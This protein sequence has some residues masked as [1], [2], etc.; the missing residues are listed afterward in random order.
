MKL[1]KIFKVC[2][3]IFLI[4]FAFEKNELAQEID[5]NE[6]SFVHVEYVLRNFNLN[7]KDVDKC[8][9][10]TLESAIHKYNSEIKYTFREWAESIFKHTLT[11]NIILIRRIKDKLR[12]VVTRAQNK[13][14]TTNIITNAKNQNVSDK[15]SN[16]TITFYYLIDYTIKTPLGSSYKVED[17]INTNIS[18][19][20]D[21][22]ILIDHI[23]LK[24]DFK[25][26]VL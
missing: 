12:K 16:K 21:Q 7:I 25:P 24:G 2:K 3:N 13:E 1:L 14:K 4:P 6:S 17:D 18:I 10:E 9:K 22:Q 23:I 19:T 20:N 15:E 11:R 8:V 5:I 26:K